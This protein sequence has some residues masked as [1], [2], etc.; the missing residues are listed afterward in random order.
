MRELAGQLKPHKPLISLALVAPLSPY[1]CAL[2]DFGSGRQL[3]PHVV[4]DGGLVCEGSYK[5]LYPIIFGTPTPRRSLDE[6]CRDFQDQQNYS[7][8]R[9]KAILPKAWLAVYSVRNKKLGTH[10]GPVSE[11]MDAIYSLVSCGYIIANHYGFLCDSLLSGEEAKTLDP[12]RMDSI[13]LKTVEELLTPVPLLS[14]IVRFTASGPIIIA[15][16]RLTQTEEIGLIL[17]GL[18]AIASE[19]SQDLVETLLDES[20]RRIGRAT[21]AVKISQMRADGLLIKEKIAFSEKGRQW[22]VGVVNRLHG[23]HSSSQGS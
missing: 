20:G 7:D 5:T 4:A 8:V 16:D 10:Y 14:Q 19:A 18:E 13:I 17:F 22:I 9:V 15:Q 2:A 21:L 6:I 11:K 23:V 1:V 12:D 3:Y